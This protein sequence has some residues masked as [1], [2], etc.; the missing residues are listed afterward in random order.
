MTI[1]IL[2]WLPHGKP[3]PKGYKLS[4]KDVGHHSR[5]AVLIAKKV[6]PKRKVAA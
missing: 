1:T 2:R 5:Y 4:S 6:K 3:M